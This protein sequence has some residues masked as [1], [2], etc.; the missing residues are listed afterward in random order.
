MEHCLYYVRRGRGDG[1]EVVM[2]LAGV[3]KKSRKIK[4]NIDG[5]VTFVFDKTRENEWFDYMGF[6]DDC[7]QLNSS[8]LEETI[9]KR[10]Y[11]SGGKEWEVLDIDGKYDEFADGIVVDVLKDFAKKWLTIYIKIEE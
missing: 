3:N 1:C 11:E 4:W 6:I 5:L 10:W 9:S 7:K 2:K 8:H